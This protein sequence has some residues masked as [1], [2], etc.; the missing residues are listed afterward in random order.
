[1]ENLLTLP[2][3]PHPA[4]ARATDA[5]AT[6]RAIAGTSTRLVARLEQNSPAM[7]EPVL[8][9]LEDLKAG[10]STLQGVEGAPEGSEPSRI[11]WLDVWGIG[12]GAAELG[13]LLA[14]ELRTN[15]V[16]TFSLLEAVPTHEPALRLGPALK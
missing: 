3:T 4:D 8:E 16:D 12:Q 15:G 2:S 1:M 10:L 13:G 14:E 5:R 11:E 6:L 9:A 7:P